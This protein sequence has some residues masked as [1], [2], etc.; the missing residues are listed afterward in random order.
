[1]GT[2]GEGANKGGAASGVV[3]EDLFD[4]ARASRDGSHFHREVITE[5]STRILG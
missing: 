3:L 2:V 4:R 1:M 5:W